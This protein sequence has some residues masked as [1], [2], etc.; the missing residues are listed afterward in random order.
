MHP[1]CFVIAPARAATARRNRKAAW[2]RIDPTLK[3]IGSVVDDQDDTSPDSPKPTEDRFAGL[4]PRHRLPKG[5]A[6]D[7]RYAKIMEVMQ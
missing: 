4:T 3:P 1:P 5:C 2:L 7:S 6:A